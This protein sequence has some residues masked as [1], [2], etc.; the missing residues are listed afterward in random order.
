[1]DNPIPQDRLS[2]RWNQ[3]KQVLISIFIGFV[4]SVLTV[5]FQE[6]VGLLKEIP[7][8]VPGGAVGMI[9]YISK[10]TSSHIA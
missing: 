8:E 5:L 4:I 7:A 2:D 1:M 10:W 9:R 3:S 6:V